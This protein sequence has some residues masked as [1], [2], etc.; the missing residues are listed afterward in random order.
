LL[1]LVSVLD[2]VIFIVGVILL[3]LEIFVIPGFGIFGILGIIM[4]IGGLFLGLISDLP[5]FDLSFI[6]GA[7]IQLAAAL[8]LSGVLIFILTRTLTKTTLWNRLI[9][10][11]G[12]DVSSGYTSKPEVNDLLGKRGKALTDLRPSGTAQIEGKRIDVVTQGDYIIAGAKIIV[13]D[14]EGSKVVVRKV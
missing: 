2:V 12:I 5:V 1:D 7:L 9:L 4:I 3:L 8:V 13:E 10:N 11:A 14:V 6:S